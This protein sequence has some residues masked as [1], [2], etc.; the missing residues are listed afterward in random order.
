MKKL[1]Y[2]FLLLPFS[3][4]MSCK[5]DNEFSPV[6]LTV[7]VSG[8]TEYNGAFYAVA[9][10]DITILSFTPKAIDGKAT[11]LAN[12]VFYLNDAPLL[13]QFGY[14]AMGTFST[15]GLPPGTYSLSMTGNLLQVDSPIKIFAVSYPIVLVEN[16]ESLPAEAP[17][18]GTYSLTIR[19]E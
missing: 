17:E 15:Q 16:E 13:D 19:G 9:G 5:D 11:D 14:P 7:T 6:D 12:V 18:F 3:L 2:L 10:D 4:L 1:F 8:V